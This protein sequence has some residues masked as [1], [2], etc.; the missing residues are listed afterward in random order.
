MP[1][2]VGIVDLI[3]RRATRSPYARLMNANFAS[4]MPQAIAVWAA[5]LGCDVRYVI[6]TGSEALPDALPADVDVLFVSAFTPAA[7]LAYAI[8]HRYRRRGVVTVLG[9]PH[10]R[11]YPGD[12]IRHFDWAVELADRALVEDLLRDAGPNPRGGV[13]I[14]ARG[15]PS[16]LPGVRA[17]WPY[18]RQAMAKAPFFTAV[19]VIGS[20]GCPYTCEFCTDATIPYRPLPYDQLREDLRFVCRELPRPVVGWHDPNFGVRFDDYMRIID[21]AVPPG[22]VRFV[23]ESSLSLLSEP[24]LRQL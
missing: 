16:E 3:A 21:D 9:G 13:R 18:I 8:S 22:R 12:A 5:Q 19:P 20:F 10:A 15:Q 14:S 17:R 4:I 6:Y 2:R 11:A 24:H 23:A 7:Y 1:R